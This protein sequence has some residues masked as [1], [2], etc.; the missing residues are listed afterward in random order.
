MLNLG[1]AALVE[2]A[3]KTA[4]YEQTVVITVLGKSIST[5]IVMDGT[6]PVFDQALLAAYLKVTG[7]LDA[8]VSKAIQL[9]AMDFTDN[10]Y[11]SP[12]QDMRKK[13]DYVGVKIYQAPRGVGYAITFGCAGD[14]H[15]YTHEYVNG[16]PEGH[17]STDG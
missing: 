9:A 4:H 8:H 16:K 2:Q 7:S 3:S 12:E 13:L 6:G 11:S 15:I 1:L 14:G 5:R 10:G 17:V